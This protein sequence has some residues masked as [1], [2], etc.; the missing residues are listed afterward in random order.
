MQRRVANLIVMVGLPVLIGQFVFDWIDSNLQ[1]AVSH[2]PIRTILV[3]SMLLL[4]AASREHRERKKKRTF[5]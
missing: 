2:L 4:W 1:S 3:F 5:R